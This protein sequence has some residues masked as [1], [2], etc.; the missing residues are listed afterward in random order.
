[1]IKKEWLWMNN[2]PNDNKIG[3]KSYMCNI[4]D[5]DDE[6]DEIDEQ[7]ALEDGVDDFIYKRKKK[8]Y[9]DDDYEY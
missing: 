7:E 4:K 8:P 6:L 9:N 2:P 3:L 5:D 1:M